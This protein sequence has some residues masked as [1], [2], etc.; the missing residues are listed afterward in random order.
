MESTLIAIEL[1]GTVN[2]LHQLQ[3]DGV[4]PISGPKKVRIIVLYSSD[5]GCE[6]EDWFQSATHNPAFEYLKDP[7]EDIYSIEDGKPFDGK[8]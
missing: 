8:I 7:E 5:D 1:S 3:L 4:I 6:E 2:E